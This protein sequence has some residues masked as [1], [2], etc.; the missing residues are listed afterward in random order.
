MTT[1]KTV[2]A[3]Y[4]LWP[5]T[6]DMAADLGAPVLDLIRARVNGLLPDRKHDAKL[7]QR[8]IF[9]DKWLRQHH[10]DDVRAGLENE[11]KLDERKAQIGDFIT[12]AGG[13]GPVANALEIDR[14]LLRVWKG[15]GYFPMRRK[16]DVI[17]L[18]D[19]IGYE[20]DADLFEVPR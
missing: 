13:V 10:L 11:P 6:Q 3:V 4:D 8:A 17:Q 12:K 20:L 5:T 19:Q 7:I 15:R 2:R 18:A 16:F 1:N 14:A 9:T